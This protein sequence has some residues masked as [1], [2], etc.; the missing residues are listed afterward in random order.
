M[1]MSNG[2]AHRSDV[3][4][5][6]AMIRRLRVGDRVRLTYPF[7]GHL[8]DGEVIKRE[9]ISVTIAWESHSWGQFYADSPIIWRCLVKLSNNRRAAA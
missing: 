1:K 6:R 3:R 4:L 5:G 9:E 7:T 2:A 8:L